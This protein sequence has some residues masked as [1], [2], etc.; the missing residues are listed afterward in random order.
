MLGHDAGI[1][2]CSTVVAG[3]AVI[4]LEAVLADGSVSGVNGC[5]ATIRVRACTAR[6]A[7]A[8]G[9]A[10]GAGAAVPTSANGPCL[11]EQA[12]RTA[13]APVAPGAAVA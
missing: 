9:A 8:R 11:A 2:L 13:G 6:A 12:A 5:D 10:S 1:G 4:A 7:R 3:A